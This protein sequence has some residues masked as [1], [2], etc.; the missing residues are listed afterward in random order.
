[1]PIMEPKCSRLSMHTCINIAT[2]ECRDAWASVWV[3]V[4]VLVWVWLS[5]WVR[6]EWLLCGL[7]DC[8][9]CSYCARPCCH[10]YER[11]IPAW[12]SDRVTVWHRVFNCSMSDSLTT[13]LYNWC[14]SLNEHYYHCYHYYYGARAWVVTCSTC[15][16]NCYSSMR[17]LRCC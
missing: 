15:A 5:V 12:L 16:I 14:S 3:R 6:F 11:L 4:W 8:R 10:I 9:G 7:V 2:Y 1:M 17:L 13:G